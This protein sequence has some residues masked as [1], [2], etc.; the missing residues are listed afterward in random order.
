[1]IRYITQIYGK[2]KMGE[3]KYVFKKLWALS[4]L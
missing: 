2:M 3:E 4:M 1:M